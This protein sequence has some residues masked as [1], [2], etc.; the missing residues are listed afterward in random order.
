MLPTANPEL[1]TPELQQSKIESCGFAA[2]AM[3]LSVQGISVS[4][5]DII[6]YF[7]RDTWM[8]F[9]EMKEFVQTQGLQGTGIHVSPSFFLQHTM[10]SIVHLKHGHF[11]IYLAELPGKKALL[12][13]PATGYIIKDTLELKELMSGYIFYTEQL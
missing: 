13:D 1:H 8:S 7:K 4:E 3:Y 10:L 6:A 11:I 9:A 2:L 12:F 5:Q